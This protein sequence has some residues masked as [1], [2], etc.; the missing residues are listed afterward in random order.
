VTFE[1]NTT[2]DNIWTKYQ[3]MVDQGYAELDLEGLT[4]MEKV[5]RIW[6]HFG[7]ELAARTPLTVLIL[8]REMAAG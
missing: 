3:A 1:D 8:R 2:E 5:D 7:E 6:E 4:P